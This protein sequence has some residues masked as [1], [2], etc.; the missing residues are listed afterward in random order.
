MSL[1]V[2]L[3]IFADLSLR[4]RPSGHFGEPGSCVAVVILCDAIGMRRKSVG[5]SDGRLSARRGKGKRNQAVRSRGHLRCY[6]WLGDDC[7]S[8]MLFT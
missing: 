2:S 8:S 5:R 4:L 1:L 6:S 3:T 7:Y